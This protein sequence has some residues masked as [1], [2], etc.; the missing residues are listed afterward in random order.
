MVNRTEQMAADPEQILDNA[1]HR[2]EPLR[3]GGRLE[4]TH[5]A[6]PVA[7]RLMRDRCAI[8]FVLPGTVD[9]GGHLGAVR[10]RVAAQLFRDQP[11]RLAALSFQQLAE[12]PFGRTLIAPRLH[13][14]VKDI[15]VLVY[16]TPQILLPPPDLDEQFVQLP[17]V[18]LAAPA[19][20]QPPR[21]GGP[22]PPTPLPNRLIRHGDTP[23]GE[24]VLDVPETQGES[25]VEPDGVTD[26]LRGKS[27]SAVAG[28]LARHR[29]TLPLA[30]EL[31]KAGQELLS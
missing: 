21:I 11:S 10:R 17:S 7:G 29:A 22:K 9:H 12:E 16:G 23:F 24:E 4:P 31:D 25:V 8:V 26:D 1:V 6:L 2:C 18:A 5:L 14:D 20:P 28:R 30:A 3:L 19:V 15:A 27:V 13:E